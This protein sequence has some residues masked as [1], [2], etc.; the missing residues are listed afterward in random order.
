MCACVQHVLPD[1][2]PK[3]QPIHMQFYFKCPLGLTLYQSL[4][5]VKIILVC[6]S[7][8]AIK[9]FKAIYA[10]FFKKNV[11]AFL[12][13]WHKKGQSVGKFCYFNLKFGLFS[14]KLVVLVSFLNKKNRLK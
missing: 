14:L 10:K 5:S 6:N 12:K 2:Y 8:I 9:F 3:H 7:C 1:G 4:L 11:F 13:I